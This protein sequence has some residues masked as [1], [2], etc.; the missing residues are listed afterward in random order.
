MTVAQ[1]ILEQL[2]GSRFLA[3]TGAR[4]MVTV[5]NGL[6]MK[7]GRNTRGVTHVT[8]TLTV[9]DM[10]DMLFQR[11]HA[12]R[13]TLKA[14]KVHLYWDQLRPMFE[15]ETGLLTSLGTMGR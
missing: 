5:R 6:T 13:V 10:Y 9:H 2:G 11:V 4:D 3:M 1:T 12:H 7:V 8:I 15:R 14:E